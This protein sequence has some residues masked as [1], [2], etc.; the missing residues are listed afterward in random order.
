MMSLAFVRNSN[1]SHCTAGRTTWFWNARYGIESQTLST[2]L[3]FINTTENHDSCPLYAWKLSTS[4][5]FWYTE[6]FP[7]QIFSLLWDITFAT[8]NRDAP[9]LFSI[10]FFDT[11]IFLK[12]RRVPLRNFSVMSD[13][14]LLTENRDTLTLLCIKFFDTRIS[15]KHRRVPSLPSLVFFGTVRKNFH[16]KIVISLFFA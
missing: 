16:R 2:F 14:K 4:E 11:K 3:K 8:E 15:Q 5:F 6:W 12:H 10:K 1:F 7:L 13:K 9:I